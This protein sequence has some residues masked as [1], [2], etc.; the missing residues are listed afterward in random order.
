MQQEGG[1]ALTERPLFT[2]KI[3]AN[4]ALQAGKY[5][6]RFPIVSLQFFIDIILPA[7]L[8]PCPGFDSASNRNENQEY[9]LWG[10]GGRCLIL[11]TLPPSCAE[12]LE[13]LGASTYLNPQGQY[14]PVQG[15]FYL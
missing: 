13:I 8:W 11:T 6:V 1:I 5:R 12:C 14:R 7:A 3:Y 2:N 10:E 15:L 4:T 9:F